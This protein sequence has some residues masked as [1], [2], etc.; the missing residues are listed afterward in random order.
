MPVTRKGT[1]F[2]A[3]AFQMAP[4]YVIGKLAGFKPVMRHLRNRFVELKEAPPKFALGFSMGILV[5][6]TPFWGGHIPHVDTGGCC[7]ALEQGGRDY[8]CPNLQRVDRTLHLP[9]EFLDRCKRSRYI[10][11][12][13]AYTWRF[14]GMWL[15]I[16]GSGRSGVSC[17]KVLASH[18]VYSDLVRRS[19]SIGALLSPILKHSL[20]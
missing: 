18:K 13:W 19:Q 5:G 9:F 10:E 20:E 16:Y 4:V 12:V 11:G 3:V 7:A 15:Y 6:M 17:G 14:V 8:R 2:R 1:V